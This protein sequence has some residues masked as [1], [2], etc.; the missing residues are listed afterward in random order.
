MTD[1]SISSPQEPLAPQQLFEENQSLVYAFLQKNPIY[2]N[3]YQPEDITQEAMTAFWQAC[4]NYNPEKGAKF[5][6]FVWTYLRNH[7][8]N[9]VRQNSKQIRPTDSVETLTERG[10]I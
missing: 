3:G 6:T 10:R 5:S 2:L 4:L 8:Y 1:F 7:L 9:L